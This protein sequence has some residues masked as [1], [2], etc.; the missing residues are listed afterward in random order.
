MNLK[1]Y[2][3]DDDLMFFWYDMNYGQYPKR[4]AAN[5]I[6]ST[7]NYKI[8]YGEQARKIFNE[9]YKSWH[10]P[11]LD[12]K[13]YKLTVLFKPSLNWSEEEMLG[14]FN[15]LMKRNMYIDMYTICFVHYNYLQECVSKNYIPQMTFFDNLLHEHLRYKIPDDPANMVEHHKTIKYYTIFASEYNRITEYANTPVSYDHTQILPDVPEIKAE[16]C[17]FQ[18][19]N[20]Q[21]MTNIENNGLVCEYTTTIDVKKQKENQENKY[22]M[23]IKNVYFNY[24]QYKKGHR[25]KDMQCTPNVELINLENEKEKEIITKQIKFVGGILIEEFGLGKTLD[26]IALSYQQDRNKKFNLDNLEGKTLIICRKESIDF[27]KND[28]FNNLMHKEDKKYKTKN[29]KIYKTAVQLN[30]YT[31]RDVCDA[32]FI[33]C[34]ENFIV[35]YLSCTAN[36][37]KDCLD[38]IRVDFRNIN[39]SRVVLYNLHRVRYHT[40]D[41]FLNI[42]AQNK[43]IFDSQM[44]ESFE[45]VLEWMSNGKFDKSSIKN[46]TV[47]DFI[48]KNLFR[49]NTKESIIGEFQ[50]P[51]MYKR[52]NKIGK[53]AIAQ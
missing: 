43:W 20:L 52:I 8:Y 41:K 18:K 23:S 34:S 9:A 25:I 31:Y 49:K 15:G 33:I 50:L 51:E 10:I 27:I 11:E 12:E 7:K 48:K 29:V 36:P 39:W 53:Y 46:K 24:D 3:E 6:E 47:E 21:W 5:F 16:L 38:K 42:S 1:Q 17:E 40:Q 37:T 14:P 4:N 26:L 19:H 32:D 22:N 2:L 28:I 44:F 45:F 35:N 13:F 30:K